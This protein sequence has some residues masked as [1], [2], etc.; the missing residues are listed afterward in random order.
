MYLW[1]NVGGVKRWFRMLLMV[2]LRMNLILI[3]YYVV[4]DWIVFLMSM[5]VVVILIVVSSGVVLEL[6]DRMVFGLNVSCSLKRFFSSGMCFVVFSCVK[7]I[8]FDIWLMMMVVLVMVNVM[9]SFGMCV[10]MIMCFFLCWLLFGCVG[11]V[12]IW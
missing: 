1:L 10:F 11:G 12:F 5:I 9:V 4:W 6:N 3:V 2:F 7:V 8:V